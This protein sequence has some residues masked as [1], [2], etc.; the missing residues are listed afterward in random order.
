MDNFDNMDKEIETTN[1][2]G[3]KYLVDCSL[4]CIRCASGNNLSQVAHRNS[5]KIVG[6]VFSCGDC[7]EF[8]CDS[9]LI[10]REKLSF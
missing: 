2:I 1:K 3:N 4:S 8:I 6:Y 5:G 10:F 9:N 7:L